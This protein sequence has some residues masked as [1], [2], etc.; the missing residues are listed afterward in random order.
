M[1][2]TQEDILNSVEKSEEVEVSK[3]KKAIRRK[4][5]KA[6]PEK[7]EQRKR[8]AKASEKKNGDAGVDEFDENGKV[9]LAEKDFDNP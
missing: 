4:E 9:I 3:S 8:D 7:T 1:K 6:L 2:V 5:N